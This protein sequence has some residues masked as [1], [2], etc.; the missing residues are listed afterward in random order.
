MRNREED[1]TQSRE[2]AGRSN[3][4]SMY[5]LIFLTVLGL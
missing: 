2:N 3:D 5:L 1:L 4:E